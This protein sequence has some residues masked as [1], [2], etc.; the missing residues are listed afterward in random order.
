MIAKKMET[1]IGIVQLDESFILSLH[2]SQN[3][4]KPGIYKRL[5]NPSLKAGVS[6]E[7]RKNRTLGHQILNS[8][9][10]QVRSAISNH[11]IMSLTKTVN[12]EK[13]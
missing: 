11:S 12:F 7:S 6:H 8:R 2:Y 3:G 1:I 4:L 9:I 5:T 13:D 10:I